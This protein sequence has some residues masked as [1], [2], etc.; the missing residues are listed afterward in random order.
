MLF[1]FLHFLFK[2]GSSGDFPSIKHPKNGIFKWFNA[3]SNVKKRFHNQSY[4]GFRVNSSE[5]DLAMIAEDLAHNLNLY[6]LNISGKMAEAVDGYIIQQKNRTKKKL[7]S[8]NECSKEYKN[9]YQ[10]CKLTG[11][12]INLENYGIPSEHVD[13]M[14][15]NIIGYLPCGLIVTILGLLT[16]EFYI[17]QIILSFFIFK[18]SDHTSPTILEFILFYLGDA[19]L[20]TSAIFYFLSY[21]GIDSALTTLISLDELTSQVTSPLSESFQN[22]IEFGIPNLVSPVIENMLSIF[23]T[24]QY[25]FNETAT[26]F[27]SPTIKILQKLVSKNES[28]PGMF[29]IYNFYIYNLAK[30]FYSCSKNYSKLN[31]IS[32]YFG[33]Y[34]FSSFQ[35]E[36]QNLLDKELEFS[37]KIKELNSFFEYIYTILY[38]V[39]QYVSNLTNQK[40]YKTN[41]TFGELI[42]DFGN[43]QIYY[44]LAGLN[45]NNT[46]NSSY[47][48]LIRFGFLIFGFI[49]VFSSIFYAIVYNLHNKFSICIANTISIFPI[50]ATILMFFISFVFTELGSAEVSLSEQLEPAIDRFIT[51]VID[52][53]IPFRMI[54]FPVI[55]ITQITN[56][57]YKGEINLSSIVFPYPMNNIE[58]FVNSNKKM[59]LADSL[60]LSNIVDLNKYGDEIGDFIIKLGENYSLPTNIVSLFNN[61]EKLFRLV[62][63][64][65]KKIDGFF[66]W[67]IPMTLTTKQLRYEIKKMDPDALHELEPY[68]SQIDFYVNL[69]NSQYQIALFEI[70]EN[71]ANTLDKNDEKLINFIHSVMND[72]GSSVKLLLRNIYP[73][74]NMIKNEPF[75]SFYA[76]IRN[77]FFYDLASTAAYISI[78][79]TL[80]MIGFVFIVVLMWIRRKGMRLEDNLQLRRNESSKLD[81]AESDINVLFI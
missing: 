37:K 79:G 71:L 59:G 58:Y 32:T 13:I 40:V 47:C 41:L 16:I 6:D 57:F 38:P 55:N 65:P 5:F 50:I 24:T 9:I 44:Y 2:M 11:I 4:F 78:S 7:L 48:G 54:E 77:L 30:D 46:Q 62:S 27:L 12:N 63:Y 23:N 72:L 68:L 21:T 53:T 33:K 14:L 73:V 18:A 1:T 61:V 36:I 56:N 80:M 31:E 29:Q 74:L 22:I 35:D 49:L 75:I 64:F 20:L 43:N 69:M 15:S 28:D 8:T 51:S 39:Q 19:I 42:T 45:S 17:I 66:N 3:L 34:D 10:F 81:S 26:S 67:G 76:T 25:F 60:Q 52:I 70:Y